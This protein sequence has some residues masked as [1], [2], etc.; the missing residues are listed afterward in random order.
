MA[1]IRKRRTKRGE[2]RYDVRY[3]LGGHDAPVLHGGTFPTLRAAEIRR[4]L[5][6]GELAAERDPRLLLRP[7]AGA[8]EGD[9]GRTVRE[10]GDQYLASRRDVDENTRRNF[11]SC[12]RKINERFGDVPVGQVSLFAVDAWVGELAAV[13]KPGTT[14][15]F[16]TKLALLLD[17]AGLDPNPARDRRVKLPK[18]VKPEPN[19]PPAEHVEA[20]LR[21]LPPRWRLLHVLVEQTALR[22]SEGVELVWG[23]VDV[24]G[25]R[26][27]LSASATKTDRA[28]Y[29]P[30]PPW[31]TDALEVTCPPEDRD[32]DRRV[33]PG[34]KVNSFRVALTRACRTARVPSYTIRDLRHRRITRWQQ[35]LPPANVAALAGHANPTTTLSVYSHVLSP[36][37]L[38]AETLIGLLAE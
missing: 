15:Q 38:P 21:V 32:A 5:I 28:R 3:R 6:R 25:S 1:S 27:R 9:P 29:V 26:L 36:A 35:E 2:R 13:H 8:R 19:P 4:E 33:F 16:L 11:R 7:V 31:L 23:D 10:W 24:R 30:M 18:Y 37:E 34:A 17:Y 22:A 12:Q 14:R 20:V